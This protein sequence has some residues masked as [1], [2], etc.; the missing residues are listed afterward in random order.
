MSMMHFLFRAPLPTLSLLAILCAAP[1]GC[2]SG[3]A[4]EGADSAEQRVAGE[5]PAPGELSGQGLPE[6]P[7]VLLGAADKEGQA[8]DAAAADSDSAVVSRAELDALIKKGPSFPLSMVQVEPARTDGRFTGFRVVEIHEFARPVLSR[9]LQKGDVITHLN[10]VRV[11]KPDD[12][13]NAWKLLAEV[14]ELRID[15]LRD[16]QPQHA[17]WTVQ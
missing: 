2:A 8:A 5:P 6:G 15:F 4:A 10:G 7:E 9:K 16:S 1:I 17:V 3:S 13:L 12:Y 11:R 14:S